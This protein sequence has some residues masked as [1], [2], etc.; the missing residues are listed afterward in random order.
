MTASDDMARFA[1][2]EDDSMILA[3]LMCPFCL[4]RPTRVLVDDRSG[5]ATAS[6][7]CAQCRADWAVALD[8]AQALELFMSPPRGLWIRHR[9]G[10]EGGSR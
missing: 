3:S 4:S 6:C 9:F 2:G 8:P 7:A 5:G 1:P 10:R